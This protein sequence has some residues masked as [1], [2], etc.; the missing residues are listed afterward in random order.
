VSDSV[1][2]HPSAQTGEQIEL[3][4]FD[5]GG[6]LVRFSGLAVLCELTGSSSELEVAAR[7]LMSPWVRRFEAGACSEEEFAAG[8]VQEWQLPYSAAEFIEIFPTWLDSPFAGGEQLLSELSGRVKLGCLSNT[9]PVGWRAIE[10][11]PHTRLFQYRFLSF[12]L[13]AVKPDPAIYERVIDRLDVPPSSV[14][15]LDDVALN[16]DAARAAGLR[17]EQAV[18]IAGARAALESYGLVG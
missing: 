17:S 9:N 10:D 3:V 16:V 12:E 5:L 7:W 2:A 18:G 4:L 11:W 1:N 13:G 15:F 6:V 14:L 8:L